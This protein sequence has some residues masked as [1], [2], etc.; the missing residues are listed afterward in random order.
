MAKREVEFER[1]VLDSIK[2]VFIHKE[3]EN[4]SIAHRIKSRFEKERIEVI[5]SDDFVIS[6][7]RDWNLYLKS[8]KGK[9][10]R[11]CPG[12]KFYNCCGYL[13]LHTGEGC[14]IGCIYCVLQAYFNDRILKIWANQE[15]LFCELEK[16]FSKKNIRFRIGTG[17]FIDSLA[18]EFLTSYHSDLLNFLNNF[19]NVCLEIKTKTCDLSWLDSTKRVDRILPAWSVNA[20]K[21]QSRYEGISC[22]IEE[23]LKS[24]SFCQSLGFRICLHFDP[25]LYFPGW[26]RAYKEVIEM[27]G[28][29][30][31]PKGIAY[32]SLGSF[33]GMPSLFK[34]I[35][36][37]HPDS[38]FI[39]GEFIQGL[40]GKMRL[41]RPIRI[42]QF[43]FILN[44]LIK[45]G[46][47]KEQIYFCMESDEVWRAVFGYTPKD[48]G[49]LY[50]HLLNRAFVFNKPLYLFIGR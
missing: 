35:E 17:E 3:V 15:D 25:I 2:K 34:M 30:I 42:K 16:I 13:I 24:A 45:I 46:I 23:R 19:D 48:F 27:I 8:Y 1:K 36:K 7:N 9:F 39:Y 38:E 18:L 29:Y 32:I 28:D 14:P 31:N 5:E 21:V 49:G 11:K 40:D 47:K 37:N 22:S 12:T 33:R 26:E 20:L 4:T 44:H 41:F 10:L 43:R 50:L 6:N